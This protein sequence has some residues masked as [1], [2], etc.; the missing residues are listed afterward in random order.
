[1]TVMSS[2]A[3]KEPAPGTREDLTHPLWK[4][5]VGNTIHCAA[6]TATGIILALVIT[7]LLS[8]PIWLDL[9]VESLARFALVLSIFQKLLHAAHHGRPIPPERA[10]E[11]HAGIYWRE[12]MAPTLM[13]IE[14]DQ[15]SVSSKIPT[16]LP[17][18]LQHLNTNFVS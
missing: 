8:L 15:K 7:A 13:L 5:G 11:F 17:S 4:H 6:G 14:D 16:C 1:M 10:R 18:V 9:S 3:D 2:N 12:R